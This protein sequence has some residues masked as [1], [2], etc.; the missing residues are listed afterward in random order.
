MQAFRVLE[1]EQILDQIQL[2]VQ[3]RIVQAAEAELLLLA[4]TRH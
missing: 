2:L 4:D 1:V 3:E